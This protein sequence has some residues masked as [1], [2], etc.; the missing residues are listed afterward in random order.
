MS[1]EFDPKK[2]TANLRKHGVSFAEAE[3]A[4]YDPMA[5]TR[6][7]DDATAELRFLTVGTGALGRVPMVCWTER[8]QVVRVIPARLATAKE[9]KSY[10]S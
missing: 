2:A 3:P 6:E 4:L 7:D 8:N 9:R 5:L 1:F 10:E